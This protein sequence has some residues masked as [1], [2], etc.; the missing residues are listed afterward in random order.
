MQ[1]KSCCLLCRCCSGS[2]L[3]LKL[4]SNRG[5][6]RDWTRG[7]RLYTLPFVFREC[8]NVR[9]HPGRR[10]ITAWLIK[11]PFCPPSDSWKVVK[12][13]WPT[14]P[15]KKWNT[16]CVSTVSV[17]VSASVWTRE[18]ALQGHIR[19]H[20]RF[21]PTIKPQLKYGSS[22]IFVC[23]CAR[24]HVNTQSVTNDWI[25]DLL[26]FP[27]PEISQW[28]SMQNEYNL[29]FS[30]YFTGNATTTNNE[31]ICILSFLGVFLLY[32]AAI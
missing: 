30:V 31:K 32:K 19:P 13:W 3:N 17:A 22:I 14:R 18:R 4:L 26:R 28:E 20:T 11:V 7:A 10:S 25:Y 29:L 21:D 1:W 27:H 9:L 24:V 23:T 15:W 2:S 16:S 12:P 6:G 8:V 5:D